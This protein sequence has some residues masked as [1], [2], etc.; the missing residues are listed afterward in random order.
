MILEYDIIVIG[1]GHAGCE[2]ASAAARLGSRTLLLTMDMTKMASMSCNPAVGGVAKGQIVR[3]IDALGGQ[4]GRITDLTTIQFRMLNRSKGAAMWSP[5]AQ[6]DKSRFSAQWRHTLENTVNLYIWQD[7]ATELLFDTAGV[8]PRIKGV[9]TQMGIEFACRAVVLTSG[10]FLGGMMHCGTS[11]AEGGRAG[12]AASHGITESLRAIGFETGRMKTGTPARLDA[13]TIDFES[14]E[15][16][17]GDENPDKFSFS[18]DTQPVKHQLP[19]FLVYTTTEVH[20]LLRTGFDRSPLFNGTIKGIGPRYCPSIEDKLRTFADK[21]Q[22]QLFLEPEGESTNEYYLNGFSSSLPWDIQWEALHKIRGFEDLHIFRPGYA[23]EYDYFP[24]TQLHHSLETKLVSGL[25]FAGQVNGT[26]G[27]EEAAA[28]G[29]IAGIN[30]HR[31]LKGEEAV[32]LQRDEAYIGVLID[33][34]VT[35]GVDE[36]Y[37]MF[38]SRAEYRILL[39]QDNA[40]LRL[41]PIG[42]KIGLISQKRY[43]H[44]T[45]KKAS[46]ESLISFARRQSIKAAEINDYLES[47][48]S[49][50]LTQGRKLY[51]IL[52]RNNVTFESLSEALLKLRK[53]ISDNNIS[54]EAIEEAEIQI[55]YKGYIEREKFIAEKLHRLENIRIPEDF[56]FHSMNSLTIEARQKLTRIRP[57]T[58]G[59]ASRIPGVSPADVNVLLVKFGR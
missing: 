47:V 34:L 33:D 37:R 50:P 41:T 2:A 26:T 14:L 54:A 36:P 42:Y 12:D 15:P 39:R 29:L 56:D 20:D 38:T 19:C 3:E 46:V 5:R 52:M 58:I 59:Q 21:D 16:Q 32:V 8:K 1:G 57:A 25:Y 53:F 9:R 44:F 45:E 13:R 27:Y 49:E 22:H 51:D 17:Y 40:D 28:Q 6:C 31:A 10:T 4:M 48:N 24:P 35:K 11:H 18:P 30:A 7:A 55:K 43:A 23:I